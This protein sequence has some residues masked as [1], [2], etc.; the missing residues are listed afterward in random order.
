M[1][2]LY[3][4]VNGRF[5][6]ETAPVRLSDLTTWRVGGPAVCFDASSEE[7][8][9]SFLGFAEDTGTPW[10]VL[11]GG[12]NILASDRG[13]DEVVVR[14]TGALAAV[15][16][17]GDGGERV[18]DCGA[19]ARLPSLSGAACTRG[20]AG[21]EFA[22]GIPGTVGG[23]VFMN[24]GAYGSSF[25]DH[26]SEV[27]V[28]EQGGEKRIIEAADCGFGYRSSMFQEKRVVVTSARLRL[29]RGDPA[30]L[31]SEARRI[32]R[33]RREK[34]PLDMPNAGS[35]FRRPDEDVPPGRLIEEAGLKGRTVGGAMVSRKHANFI[36][37]T[38]EATSEDIAELI[39]T[40]KETV[41]VRFGIL[42]REEVRYLGSGPLR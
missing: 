25:S 19:G 28:L 11:G 14:L 21:L 5:P 42:L 34:F 32:L 36:V 39:G 20:A 12:S 41:L 2:D 40:V 6:R 31:R 9:S 22:I 4:L 37:N 26:V 1:N 27:S 15:S 29:R 35:V 3:G 23:A 13:C 33:V 7:V 8:L 38:G 30:I 16:W 10:V 17:S 24:A 18:A